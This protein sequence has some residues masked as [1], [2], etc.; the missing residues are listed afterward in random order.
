[1]TYINSIQQVSI[2][3]GST[4]LTNTATITAVGANAFI[5]YQGFTTSNSAALLEA[6]WL[7]NGVL[8]NST[9][10]TVTRNTGTG[11]GVYNF[12]V[13]DPGSSLVTGV[14]AG[15]VS[16]S[17]STSGTATITSV[18]TTLSAVFYLGS[19][20]STA[21]PTELTSLCGV[22]LTNATTVTATCNSAGTNTV[23]FVV[24]TFAAGA[25]KSIQQI[26]NTAT[27]S[28]TSDV[29]TI[30]SVSM[31]NTMLAYGG[32][33][34]AGTTAV[35]SHKTQQLTSATQV[36]FAWNSADATSRTNYCTV[37]EFDPSV[38]VYVTRGLVTSAST[39][40]GTLAL[41]QVVTGNTILNYLNASTS[42]VI[43][44]PDQI[45]ERATLT[46]SSSATT[47]R[48]T[49]GTITCIT[50]LEAIEFAASAY[51]PWMTE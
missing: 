19:Q 16:I 13:I 21:S 49:A 37:I 9:T 1:M 27:A 8:T 2:S 28:S 36:T 24:V 25:I 7:A 50:S 20:T 22:T 26:A 47:T 14:Q 34:T 38:R 32:L 18:D 17:A 43:G 40:T 5:I 41:P 4:V 39:A 35:K 48:N 33:K 31:P 42:G 51:R 12:V 44:N 10:V 45:W 6:S 11:T 46:N 23:G 15:T 30:T 3:L 29:V